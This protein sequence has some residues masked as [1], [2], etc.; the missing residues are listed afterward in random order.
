MEGVEDS[1]GW[2][3]RGEFLT[4]PR[5]APTAETQGAFTEEASKSSRL[6][7]GGELRLYLVFDKRLSCPTTSLVCLLVKTRSSTQFSY[8]QR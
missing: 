2:A 5:P 4:C 8:I 6:S 1:K 7:P 3:E